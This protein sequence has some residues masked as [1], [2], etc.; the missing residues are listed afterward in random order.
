MNRIIAF[1]ARYPWLVLLIIVS[2]SL[3]AGSRVDDLRLNISAE[4][5]LVEDHPDRTFFDSM[6]TVFGSDTATMVYFEDRDL[7]TPEKLA[8]IGNIVKRIDDLPFVNRTE[9]LYSINNIRTVDGF[10]T[11]AP[12]LGEIPASVAEAEAIRDQAL[13]NPLINSNL[14]S[15]DGQAMAITV[16]FDSARNDPAFDQQVQAALS[17][18]LKPLDA[19]LEQV[20]HVGTPYVRN[21]VGQKIR[22]DQR[23]ILP[24]SLAVLIMT[25]GM[26]LRR[27]TAALI[28]LLTAGLSILW[29]LGLMA[30]RDIPVNVMTSIVP[31]L[32]III[33]STEDIHMLAEYHVGRSSGLSRADAIS[34]MANHMGTAVFLTF[35]TT[36]MGFLSIALNDLAL[37]KQFGLVASTGLL[38]NFIITVMLVPVSLHFMGGQASSSRAGGKDGFRRFAEFLYQ[39]AST[40]KR[41]ILGLAVLVMAVS[42]AGATLLRV[43]NNPMAYFEDDDELIRNATMLHDRIAGMRT[44]SVVV[45][46]T[47]GTFLKVPYLQELQLLQGFIESQPEFD[48]T[49][50]FADFIGIV[51]GG[52]DATWQDAVY[53]PENDDVV[54]EYMILID[55]DNVRSLVSREYRQARILVR[56]NIGST[57]ELNQAVDRIHAYIETSFDPDLSVRITGEAWLNAQAADY[58]AAGQARSLTLMLFVIFLIISLLFVNMRAGAIAVA[59]NLF[60]IAILFGVM[61]YAGIALDTGTAMIGAIALGVCVDHTMHFMVRFQRRSRSHGDELAAVA[62]TVAD[63]AAP[64]IATALALAAGFGAL[65]ISGFPPVAAFGKLSAMVMLLALISTF[66]L[67]PIL[68]QSTRLISVWDMLSLQLRSQVMHKCPLFKDMG[69]WQ[70]KKTILASEIHEINADERII[71][72]GDKGTEMFV[73]INGHAEVWQTHAD[74]SRY[75]INSLGPGE[76]FGEIALVAEIDRTADVIATV[77]SQ[78]LILQWIALMQ[79]RHEFEVGLYGRHFGSCHFPNAAIKQHL[80]VVQHDGARTDA[81]QQVL[82]VCDDD[83]RATLFGSIILVVGNN[84]VMYLRGTGRVQTGRGLIIEHDTWAHCQCTGNCQTFCHAAG[85]QRVITFHKCGVAW[86]ANRFKD[87]VGNGINIVIGQVSDFA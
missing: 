52:M 61:G 45:S 62:Q 40:Y 1:A 14:L 15:R 49:I 9:S 76:V 63:E 28:P 34:N 51:H 82:V 23:I 37:L 68:L 75:Q 55:H 26:T 69:S 72:Q 5:M 87:A 6:L 73:L 29:I 18:I 41:L 44:L 71:S 22:A 46:G 47:N 3:A 27:L 59:V 12:Y 83:C 79:Y 43:N 74:G 42:L 38:L 36:Y 24:L 39:M 33:G 30:Y 67:L 64:I 85:Q 80:A 84:Q 58:M 31:A 65:A 56:H 19:Q 70:I 10:V 81:L 32:L 2:I 57:W 66:V 21:A 11:I 25:L 4:G 8:A 50:S 48:K 60:P 78:V 77:P 86:Q 16:Y 17:R 7:F 35:I 54:S 13:L 20:F 53:L